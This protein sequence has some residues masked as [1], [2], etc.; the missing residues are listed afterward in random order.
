M[1]ILDNCLLSISK[2]NLDLDYEIILIDNLSKDL[3]TKKIIKKWLMH[4]GH[5]M[6][7]Y[8]YK[9]DFNYSKIHNFHN[10]NLDYL[11]FLNNDTEIITKNW[12][13]E[14][15]KFAQKPRIGAVGT[16]LLYPNHKIQHAGV[17]LGL[18]GGAAHAYRN[19][20]MP[21]IDYFH[22][23]KVAN[24]FSSVT[25]ACMMCKRED[26]FKVGGF[27]EDFS[28]NYN[29]VDICLKSVE[30]GLLMSFYRM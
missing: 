11:L 13:F 6:R 12:I 3:E 7:L 16:L 24:N 23:S 30:K 5:K 4:F 8:E 21:Q 29:D 27:N 15:L 22:R 18:G 1:E 10:P 9:D 2:S 26:F 28:H 17:I 19:Y 20:S 25:A 14:M